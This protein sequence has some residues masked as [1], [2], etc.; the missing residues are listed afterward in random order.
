[1]T[2]PNTL[3]LWWR[4]DHVPQLIQTWILGLGLTLGLLCHIYQCLATTVSRPDSDVLT[5]CVSLT[6]D[7]LCHYR[8]VWWSGLLAE[9]TE[10]FTNADLYISLWR[11]RVLLSLFW[12]QGNVNIKCFAC[13]PDFGFHFKILETWFFRSHYHCE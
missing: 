2:S 8:L 10:C 12:R 7:L 6:L 3:Q 11:R 1:M 13:S 5:Q 9:F 4:P